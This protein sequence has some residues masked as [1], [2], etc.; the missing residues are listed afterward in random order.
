MCQLDLRILE[1]SEIAGFAHQ[2]S[3]RPPLFA[4]LIDEMASDEPGRTGYQ[5][6]SGIT[7]LFHMITRSI[8]NWAA[9]DD[10]MEDTEDV[11]GAAANH[12][13]EPVRKAV[14]YFRAA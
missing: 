14:S 1:V 12:S 7:R 11:S 6:R 2:T 8:S 10:R 3:D 9:T 4:Q 5:N 13:A